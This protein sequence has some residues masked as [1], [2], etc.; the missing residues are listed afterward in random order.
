MEHRHYKG[1][2]QHWAKKK[3]TKILR[4]GLRMALKLDELNRRECRTAVANERWDWG[5]ATK[6]TFTQQ[7]LMLNLD[8]FPEIRF[9]FSWSFILLQP[10]WHF[11]VNGLQKSHRNLWRNI[12]VT[13]Q[14]TVYGSKNAC[15][16]LCIDFKGFSGYSADSIVTRP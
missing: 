1:K 12:D 6:A 9:L 3:K 7:V 4:Q 16:R 5:K 14:H 15:S 10:H 11:C 8:F 2:I 13:Q